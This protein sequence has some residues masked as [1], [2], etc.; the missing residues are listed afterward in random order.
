MKKIA[1]LIPLLALV[2]AGCIYTNENTDVKELQEKVEQLQKDVAE[3]Q[4]ANG[5]K[6]AAKNEEATTAKQKDVNASNPADTTS[7]EHEAIEAIKY[8]LRMYKSDLKYDKISSV[9]KSDGTVDVIID[10]KSY[11]DVRHTYYNVSVYGC[12]EYCVKDISGFHAGHFPYGDKFRV[13]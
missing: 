3:L 5:I 9:S 11:G 7:K 12:G 8:C 6:P 1:I 13:E 4:K 2:C 10:Y